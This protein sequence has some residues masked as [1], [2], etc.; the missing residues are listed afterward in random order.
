MMLRY[1]SLPFKGKESKS[2]YSVFSFNTF[3]FR[4]HD[5][6]SNQLDNQRKTHT[7]INAHDFSLACFQ[8]YPMK[9]A[10]HA[11][12][13]AN[14][15]DGLELPH[16]HLS[17]YHPEDKSAHNI[18]VTA[19]AFPLV[20]MGTLVHGGTD[21]AMYSDIAFPG[22]T[23]RIY[24]IHLQSV[25][26]TK[27][28]KLLLLPVDSFNPR[29]IHHYLIGAYN[30]LSTAFLVRELQA[31]MLKKSIL[32]SPY[33]VLIAGDFNDTPVSYA[34]Q[35]IS[36]GM[37]D[38][39]YLSTTGF[40]RTFKFSSFPLQ[41]DYI[42]HDTSFKSSEYRFFVSPVSDHKAISSKFNIQE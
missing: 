38:A 34:Y 35:I 4:I 5:S 18:F 40:I 27:E 11:P 16:K 42:M 15:M 7:L 26:F 19:S 23:I 10:R 13:Y 8:E 24:N 37:K 39:S 32:E 14:L 25:K 12:F 29:T 30:K 22:K 21:F 3:G 2:D 36:E 6:L 17:N 28:R 31:T 41:I 33:P 20:F 1:F 9:G